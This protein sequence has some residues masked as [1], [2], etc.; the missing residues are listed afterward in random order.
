VRRSNVWI[1]LAAATVNSAFFINFCATVF[2]CGC[3]SLWAGADARCNVHLAGSHHCPWC[4]NGLAA[5]IVP[6]SLIAAVQAV[7]SFWPRSMPAARRLIF[8]VMAFPAAGAVIA[9][10]YGLISAY[11]NGSGP[12]TQ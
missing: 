4:A 2:Q 3:A 1:F 10:L 12:R 8:A 7:I 5:S 11:W 6:W 9:V